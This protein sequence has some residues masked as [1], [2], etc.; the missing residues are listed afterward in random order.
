MQTDQIPKYV[1]STHPNFRSTMILRS[2][3]GD[4]SILK[5][6]RMESMQTK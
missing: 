4:T 1:M 2:D 6:I 3:T 5:T